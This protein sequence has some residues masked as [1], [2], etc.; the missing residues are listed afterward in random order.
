MAGGLFPSSLR[1]RIACKS[2]RDNLPKLAP[3]RFILKLV[4]SGPEQS[5]V[6]SS[7]L[8]YN[9]VLN[10]QSAFLVWRT[11]YCRAGL[12]RPI[13][14]AVRSGPFLAAGAAMCP[15]GSGHIINKAT[16]SHLPCNWFIPER[17][18]VAKFTCKYLV[19]SIHVGA[20][21]IRRAIILTSM[22]PGLGLNSIAYC[23]YHI[24]DPS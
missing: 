20:C 22:S 8:L 13:L 24:V 4:C 10:W 6:L 12:T 2:A 19:T 17:R 7:V 14:T 5:Q 1:L 23:I 16:G 11:Q 9:Q 18:A 15:Y 21:R 3:V